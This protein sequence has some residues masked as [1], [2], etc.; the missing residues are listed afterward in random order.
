MSDE[1]S[2]VLHTIHIEAQRLE[3]LLGE[4]A[5]ILKSARDAD[6]LETVV[7]QKMDLV[8]HL[9]LLEIR[10]RQLTSATDKDDDALWQ[11]SLTILSRCQAL[12]AQAGADISTQARY[13]KR[14]LEILGA[15][16]NDTPIYSAG[17]ETLGPLGGQQL[18]KA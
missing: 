4:E 5:L 3:A 7:Q 6:Q 17:G 13:G 14:A 12:N 15:S 10:R 9:E 8:Q 11:A 16:N 18:G 2:E 1:L